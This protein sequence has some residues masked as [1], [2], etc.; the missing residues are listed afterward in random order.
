VRRPI[1]FFAISVLFGTT[2]YVAS[3]VI[4]ESRAAAASIEVQAPEQ[5]RPAQAAPKQEAAKAQQPTK[6]PEEPAKPDL[7][8]R[9]TEQSHERQKRQELCRK[10][11]QRRQELRHEQQAQAQTKPSGQTH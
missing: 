9:H 4:A 7:L 11:E 10:L 2:F 8:A 5:Q 1:A 3:H 6:H